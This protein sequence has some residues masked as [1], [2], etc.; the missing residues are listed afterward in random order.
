MISISILAYSNLVIK[1]RV[2]RLRWVVD[3]SGDQLKFFLE[4]FAT[5]QMSVAL[6]LYAMLKHQ[7]QD[8]L[9][10]EV[11]VRADG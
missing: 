1:L 10:V 5:F 9:Q 3:N 6:G 4:M 11:F 8:N 2:S 7:D